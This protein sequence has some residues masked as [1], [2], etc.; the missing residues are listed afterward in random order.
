MDREGQ[1]RGGCSVKLKATALLAF[2]ITACGGCASGSAAEGDQ[3]ASCWRG[4]ALTLCFDGRGTVT[5][6]TFMFDDHNSS[7]GFQTLA[8][9]W[10]SDG[11][12]HFEVRDPQS[13]NISWPWE[14]TRVSCALGG[15]QD[16]M[17]L[18]ACNGSGQSTRDGAPVAQRDL[19]LCLVPIEES[20]PCK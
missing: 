18:N 20:A 11:D 4:E 13:I 15:P 14:W 10:G 12:I 5:S 6:S 3:K 7:V 16:V 8:K 2:L 9:Y 19:T 1:S 17:A